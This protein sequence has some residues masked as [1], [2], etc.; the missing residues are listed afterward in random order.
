M[1]EKLKSK[2]LKL[3]FLANQIAVFEPWNDLKEKDRLAYIWKDKSK[4]VLFSFLGG[5]TQK[6]GIACYIGEEN[7]MKARE[8]L[9]SKNEKHEPVFMLQ[10]AFVCLWD[11][12]EDLRKS[13]YEL[14][15]EL[16]FKFRGRGAWLHFDRYEIGYVPVPLEEKD[17]D[18]LTTAFENLHMMLRAIYE[19]GLDPEFDKGKT[20]LRWYEPKDK[21]YY[22]HPFEIT[23]PADITKAPVVTIHEN[24]W[25]RNVRS[26]PNARYSVELD[27]SYLD[28][29]FVDKDGRETFPQLLLAV[30]HESGCIIVNQMLS[31]SCN[32][33]NIIF[34]MLD[35]FTEQFGKPT[36]IMICDDS[37][38]GILKD[39]CEKVGIKLTLRKKLLKINSA[40]KEI[41]ERFII[42]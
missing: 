20:L 5:S 35:H 16:G 30:D 41:I 26:M 21:L 17:I 23:F 8:I 28:V 2:W 39:V 19:Q 11:N 34:N 37:L 10:N 15:K 6:C 33:T 1:K 38:K 42:I 25:M 32:K 13:D 27:W 40:R 29:I 3:Y 18:L 7:Y 12:R 22:T 36:E 9:T 31:P 4:T 14:I 24:E